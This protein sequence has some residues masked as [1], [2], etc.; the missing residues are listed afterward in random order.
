MFLVI[1][2]IG[3]TPQDYISSSSDP[4]LVA[5]I[6][7][8]EQNTKKNPAKNTLNPT[9][10]KVFEL[11]CTLPHDHTLSLT[12]MDY[13]RG[14]LR[15]DVIGSTEIDVENRFYS[16]HRATVGIPEMFKT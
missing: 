9:F 1:Q 8:Q 12:V 14:R 15:D 3:L 10:G 7:D 2:A 16:C 5:E 6:G 4:Y 11:T 13:D